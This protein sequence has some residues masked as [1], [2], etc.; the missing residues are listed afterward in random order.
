ML[1]P[2]GD[3]KILLVQ[4]SKA[5]SGLETIS[6]LTLRQILTMLQLVF[7]NYHKCGNQVF[8]ALVSQR[9]TISV[10][11]LASN[12]RLWPAEI[13]LKKELAGLM[14]QQMGSHICSPL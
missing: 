14:F 3:L 1:L 5:A 6:L 11:L 10:F 4:N 9:S 13:S 2:L 8:D 7:R 12:E